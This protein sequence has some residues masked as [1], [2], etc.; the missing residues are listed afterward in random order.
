LRRLPPESLRRL[1]SVFTFE[2]E[3]HGRIKAIASQPKCPTRA[4][5][6]R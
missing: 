4:Q 2:T 3:N 1:P 6:I 5:R